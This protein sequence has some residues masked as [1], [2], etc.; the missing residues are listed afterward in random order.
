[1]QT[2]Q[3]NNEALEKKV[4]TLIADVTGLQAEE[5]D[6]GMY[7]EADL[8]LDSI[9]MVTLMN[10][11]MS[12]VDPQEIDAF[13]ERFGPSA[14]MMLQ[15][16]GDLIQLFQ[17]WESER[18][19]DGRH[20]FQEEKT[21]YSELNQLI[22]TAISSVTGHHPDDLDPGMYLESDLGLDSIKMV[23]LMN[24]LT[25]ILPP[26]KTEDFLAEHP[27][28]FL[29][30]LET[31]GDI[32][33][34]FKSF[35]TGG[36]EF[37]KEERGGQE[38]TMLNAQYPLLISYL[39]SV[40]PITISSGVRVRGRLSYETL[41][42]AWESLIRR[43]PALQAVFSADSG[44]SSLRDYKMTTV[45]DMTP[46]P[47]E[48]HL[49]SGFSA[50]EQEQRL[51]RLFEERIN[52]KFDIFTWPLHRLEAADLGGG[53]FELIL[54][55]SHLVSDG[56]GNQQLLKELLEIYDCL[57]A[58][59]KVPEH[60][61][62]VSEYNRLAASLNGW[63]HEGESEQFTAYMKQQGRA[64]YFFH[65]AFKERKQ[66]N[67]QPS[68]IH[69]ASEVYS[70]PQSQTEKLV[71]LTGEW[72]VS[73]YAIITAAFTETVRKLSDTKE[74]MIINLPTSGKVYPHEDA[75]GMVGTFAQNLAL[76]FYHSQS[77]SWEDKAR[78]ADREIRKR[79][80]DGLDRSQINQA[81]FSAKEQLT[82]VNG[83]IPKHIASAI[84]SSLKSNLYLS[85]VGQTGLQTEMET[86]R[87]TGYEAYTC[88]NPGTIDTLIEMFDGALSI[89]ANYDAGYFDKQDIERIMGEFISCLTQ[90][91]QLQNVR[92][93]ETSVQPRNMPADGD[94]VLSAV[95]ESIEKV[96]RRRLS[97][98]DA[99]KDLEASFGLDSLERIRLITNLGNTFPA[100]EKVSLFECR[101]VRELVR[102]I[103]SQLQ[104]KTEAQAPFLEIAAQSKRTPDLPAIDNQGKIMTYRELDEY[105]NRL[106][107]C[108]ADREAANGSVIGV[109]TAPG[110]NMLISI[111]AILK[112]GA[113]Y[114]PIDYELPKDRI[115][116]MMS[117]S[118]AQMLLTEAAF[119]KEAEDVS[120]PGTAVVLLDE[121]PLPEK[122]DIRFIS[123]REW[124]AYPADAPA[125]T[126]TADD[127]MTVLYT[128]GSS[129]R[130]KGV[131][132]NHKGY[133]NR[134]QWHQKLFALKKGE[135]V[136]QK[137]SCSFD[138]S[139]WE[140]FWPLMHGGTVCPVPKS[141][142]KNPWALAEW[143]R[144]NR[145]SIMHF[146]P[147]LFG[148]FIH[149]L[150]GEDLSFPHLRWI[151]FSGEA[152]PAAYIQKWI[153]ASGHHIKLANLYGPTEAS[154]D[155]TYHIIDGVPEHSVP[156]GR[157]ADNVS[158]KIVDGS[159]SEQPQGKEGEICIGGIQLSK[160]YL[161]LPDKT[162]EAF[163]KNPFPDVPG[164]FVYRT[165]D[166]AVMQEDGTI[167]YIGRFD[168]QVKIRG[169][170]VELTEIEAVLSGH[171]N[172][173]EAAVIC[174]EEIDGQKQLIAYM[175]GKP[176]DE[177]E[178][179]QYL[180]EKLAPYMIPH[181]LIWTDKLPKNAN[182]K[183]DRKAIA[184]LS[185]SQQELKIKNQAEDKD[186]LLPL[187]PAQRW[188]TAYFEFPYQWTGY[189][190]FFYNQPMD[191]EI[192]NQALGLLAGRHEVLRSYI[193]LEGSEWKQVILPEEDI[194]VSADIYDG[195]H[196]TDEERT[197]AAR[198]L[199]NEGIQQLCADRWPLWKTVV[200]K[201]ADGRYDISIIGHHLISDM[202]TNQILFKDMWSIYGSLLAGETPP[203]SKQAGAYARY[204]KHME[205]M[206][207][208][209]GA[210][211]LDYWKKEY[212]AR[213]S[214][215]LLAP[216][217]DTGPNDEQSAKIMSFTVRKDISD[218]LLGR[219]KKVYGSTVY[220]LLLAPLYTS[221]QQFTGRDG[222]IVSHRVH[223][224]K[225]GGRLY[226]ET[227]GDFALQFPLKLKI[228]KGVSWKKLI[229]QIKDGLENVPL[230]GISY[231]LCGDELPG[232]LYPDTKL[233]SVRA[234]Y[235]GNR[236]TPVFQHFEFPKGDYDKRHSLPE[237]KRIS[238][239]EYFFSAENGEITLD[240][241][242]SRNMYTD[243]TVEKL[244][245]EYMNELE[246]L[247]ADMN[248]LDQPP[249]QTLSPSAAASGQGL[250]ENKTLLVTG[251]GRGIGRAIAAKAAAEGARVVILGRNIG[252]LNETAQE[253]EAN[254]GKVRVAAADITNRQDVLRA[255]R[256]AAE[257]YGSIDTV[258]NNAGITKIGDI[259]DIPPEEWE[260]IVKV[261]L[262]GTYNVS[263]AAI[264]YLKEQKKGKVINIGSD[265]SFIGYP[266]MSAYAA[267]KHAVL[268]LTKS[269]AEELKAY[270]IQVNAVCPA[271]ADTGMTPAAL[272]P[273]SIPPEEIAEA[274]CFLASEKSNFITGEALKIYGRQD[275]H[276]F[277]SKQIPM[278]K[279]VLQ[280]K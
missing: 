221:L 218:A 146:V 12:W 210:D 185:A 274:V 224:R 90:I 87:L 178:M 250:L 21:E 180:G 114:V 77:E 43:H 245:S 93:T 65:P 175:S 29:L 101:T 131:L 271:F 169:Y 32:T 48:R 156:I 252:R 140:M 2:Q 152:L 123:K 188:L 167:H 10:E 219:A 151:L 37:D 181:R 170:R 142:L 5:L 112:T 135:R 195:T 225:A 203:V 89:S 68:C 17:G 173:K 49:F 122:T 59:L 6:R 80:A 193:R 130:P 258:V 256:E 171:D 23:T 159:L 264:P 177:A 164:D 75:T 72:K 20:D 228:E 129:G 102:G 161:H 155:V 113:A 26:D 66:M 232:Y 117:D 145:I 213:D 278:L 235:L 56:L 44:A 179:K 277:G 234:N 247:F 70:L 47:I 209:N 191:T 71:R 51:K 9:K 94:H 133:A 204:V 107:R 33:G 276:W 241:E 126:G 13:T 74:N 207:K 244:G 60:T 42:Q 138:V 40:S 100:I 231:D 153:A 83:Q 215:F 36:L 132:L 238:I 79:M 58:N 15:T 111:L 103:S 194:T 208:V 223:G 120:L 272:R 229:S 18:M 92:W 216:D 227:A 201:C 243:D 214:A 184:S 200:I 110:A 265:S 251:G 149:A 248:Q 24:E 168:Q 31:I 148:E 30:E 259:T 254:G 39:T 269:L 88:T 183:L 186:I 143:V 212:P 76:T 52:E 266:L 55:I 53:E 197:E 119:L 263:Y 199:I 11:C 28:A 25:A 230:G 91:S 7:F 127:L 125:Y 81:A 128:S 14:F 196:L 217:T 85:Y 4:F 16:I 64:R 116:Y 262:F 134:F 249:K 61:Y 144:E 260:E 67:M 34:V 78:E 1:M 118:G 255:F 141:T 273:A 105:S 22:L 233:T 115:R 137:T 237:Q 163:V 176:A 172:V 121:G 211:Y 124:S 82:L 162:G 136:A 166:L 268:G 182:G 96:C 220:P 279:T 236:N 73:L 38:L 246:K 97:V 240:I 190:R 41:Y 69:T 54:S 8:G 257:V 84:R 270:N 154:I 158:I 189:T 147:S 57:S 86:L 109:I 95:C 160:G 46:P 139:I 63:K 45:Q 19:S 242:Y 27:P 187:A 150:E 98:Q 157:P 99:D 253:I 206:K 165:G 50:E 35:L 108:L 280:H 205:E 62:T 174:T 226:L 202:M 222:V 3:F 106:A 239:L 267:S 261:N 275:M 192:F 198:K 104:P